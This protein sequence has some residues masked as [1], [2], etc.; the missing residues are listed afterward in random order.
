MAQKIEI[1]HRTIIFAVLFVVFL[2]F[3]YLIRDIIL[4]FFVALLIMAAL[5]PLVSKLSQFKIP[6]VLSVILVYILVIGAFSLLV[7][8]LIPPLVEQTTHLFSLLPSMIGNI[9]VLPVVGEPLVGELASQLGSLSSY[10]LKFTISAFSNILGLVSV[11]VM[12]FYLL[13]E[14]NKI[15]F[16]DFFG[17]IMGKKVGIFFSAWEK[18]L[19]NWLG[20]QLLLMSAVGI[21]TFLGLWLLKI[22]FSLPLAIFAGLLEIVPMIGPLVSAVPAVIVGF[23]ISPLTGLLV[24]ILYFL[25]QQIENHLLVPKVMEKSTGINPVVVLICL[26]V[27]FKLAGVLGGILAI[28]VFL[29]LSLLVKL[30]LGR[31]FS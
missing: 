17:N 1:S 27:G 20:G 30:K 9:G 25:V 14:R 4:V 10:F 5:N 13:L 8:S 16:S 15:D 28:P 22:P 3:L 24:A 11:L 26:A 19:G 29:T 31:S 6:R 23:G 18:S 2:W 21:L 12:A 7:T